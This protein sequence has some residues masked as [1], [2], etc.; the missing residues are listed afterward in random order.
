MIPIPRRMV[1]PV[2]MSVASALIVDLSV[3]AKEPDVAVSLHSV[4][5][6]WRWE[7]SWRTKSDCGPMSL[8]VLM[9]LLGHDASIDAVIQEVP[10]DETKGCALA[11]L[12]EAGNRLGC[13][14][15]SRFV[16]PS[17]L[18]ALPG[19]FIAHCN[20]SQQTGVG[21]YLVIVAHSAE[22]HRYLAINTDQDLCGWVPDATIQSQVSGYVVMP[23]DRYVGWT[24]A[25]GLCLTVGSLGLYF[26]MKRPRGLSAPAQAGG[27]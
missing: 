14:M 2:M 17:E 8:Y 15:T 6:D 12:V 7:P 18:A 24:R 26:G 16:K 22:T 21:H 11:A 19:P 4:P 20:G 9:K 5:S 1:W 23:Q 25:M 10:I 27:A 13:A 3:R